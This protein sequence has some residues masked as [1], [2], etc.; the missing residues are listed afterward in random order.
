VISLGPYANDPPDFMDWVRSV[1]DANVGRLAVRARAFPNPDEKPD[2]G[3]AINSAA[4][5]LEGVAFQGDKFSV[6]FGPRPIVSSKGIPGSGEWFFQLTDLG[7]VGDAQGRTVN[8]HRETW[9]LEAAAH[10]NFETDF[11]KAAAYVRAAETRAYFTSQALVIAGTV[12]EAEGEVVTVVVGE[13]LCGSVNATFK[14]SRGGFRQFRDGPW[15]WSVQPGD[16]GIISLNVAPP[17]TGP[18]DGGSPLPARLMINNVVDTGS[19]AADV[20]A[21]LGDPP[22]LAL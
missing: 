7:T 5:F 4:F 9:R 10:P 15:I 17:K 11:A 22:V 19:T 13:L 21:A 18:E 8:L 3:D 20:R 6:P 1:S 16:H 12:V 14:A 2:G